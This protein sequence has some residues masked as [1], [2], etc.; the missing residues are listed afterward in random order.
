MMKITLPSGAAHL[1]ESTIEDYSSSQNTRAALHEAY[2]RG[3]WKPYTPPPPP[4]PPPE[5]PNW[6]AFRLTLFDTKSFRQWAALVPADWREDL[7]IC[8]VLANAEAL[9]NTYNQ[10]SGLFKPSPTSAAEW[11]RLATQHRI[12]VTF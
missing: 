3:D 6:S 11:Q 7:K 12:P 8:A 1:I 4:P 2:N 5:P 10:I 9:Q